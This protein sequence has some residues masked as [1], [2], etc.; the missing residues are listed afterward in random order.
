MLQTKTFVFN[1]F[2]VNT[3]VVSDE[4]KHCILIDA[5][6][7]SKPEEKILTDYIDQ[8]GLKVAHIVIT[9][10]H[11]DHIVGN[12]FVCKK[13]NLK[14]L[15]HPE[16]SFF[17]ET[18]REYASV[19]D[20]HIDEVIRPE[21]FLS[22]GDELTFG[23]TRFRVLY[24]PGHATGSICLVNESD[25][26]VFTGDVLFYQSIGRTDLPT[27]NYDLL[28]RSITEKLFTL[29][30]DY[31]VLPGHGPETTIGLEKRSNPFL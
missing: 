20:M 29:P 11:I 5:A 6:C 24:T 2:A 13:Y 28:Y 9:H 7:H 16:T 4:T 10:G 26:I 23:N 25:K 1:P 31:R 18:A 30:D 17:W 8:A 19:F 12:T 3:Y 15:A 14:P 22:D 27:G 21:V